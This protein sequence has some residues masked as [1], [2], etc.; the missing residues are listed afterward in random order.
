[1]QNSIS[2]SRT[3]ATTSDK[4]L[5]VVNY[6]GLKE[7]TSAL[8]VSL[9]NSNTQML[10]IQESELTLDKAITG[11]LLNTLVKQDKKELFVLISMLIERLQDSFSFSNKMSS[12]Q[13]DML[14]IDLME[15]LKYETFEDIVLLFKMARQGALGGKI[16]R[17]DSH[18][19]TQEWLPIYL[20]K[21]SEQREAK[22]SNL[23]TV[24][25]KSKETG[26]DEQSKEKL[27][28]LNKQ[29]HYNRL[30][31]QKKQSRIPANSVLNNN[32]LF[33][34]ELQFWASTATIKQISD[35]IKKLSTSR[36]NADYI[37]I[38]KKALTESTIK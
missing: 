29:L 34:Q 14:T 8:I 32:D 9:K 21:K 33:K 25:L 10:A 15:I 35:K 6:E 1:M 4:Q 18:V 27:D 17:L 7:Q 24:D 26:W 11:T 31:K 12:S 30:E 2:S 28:L 23:K 37:K 36:A 38:L 13:I 22:H 5:Q 19:I 16:F 3:L 20:E